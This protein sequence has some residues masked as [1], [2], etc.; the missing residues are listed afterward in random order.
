M[1]ISTF[2]CSHD[3]RNKLG[4]RLTTVKSKGP[5]KGLLKK[6]GNKLSCSCGPL[7]IKGYR[8]DPGSEPWD[9]QAAIIRG[10]KTAGQGGTLLK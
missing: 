6:M 8:F 4:A 3:A 9:A 10:G 1:F 2:R 7:K 5:I